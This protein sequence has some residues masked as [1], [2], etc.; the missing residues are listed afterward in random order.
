MDDIKN[1]LYALIF[2]GGGGTRLWPLSRENKPK[3]FIKLFSDL[4][5][6]QETYQRVKN[7]ISE[8]NIYVITTSAYQKQVRQELKN[9]KPHQIIVEPEKRNTGPASFLG[10]TQIYKE[11]PDA[12]IAHIWVDHKIDNWEEYANVLYRGAKVCMDEDTLLTVGLQPDFPHTGLGYLITKQEI[13][14]DVYEVRKFIEK[15]DFETAKELVDNGGAY[16]NVGIYIGCAKKFLTSFEKYAPN[17]TENIS[18]YTKMPSISIDKAISEKIPRLLM[19]KA[20]FD[21]SDIGDFEVLWEKLSDMD[22]KGNVVVSKNDWSSIDT[23][24]SLIISETGQLVTTIGLSNMAVIVTKDAILVL[25]KDESQRIK[26]LI[27]KMKESKL[28]KY[29]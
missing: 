1:N 4:S 26:E 3:Q 28:N 15:P 18:D 8:D 2:A 24:G 14:K 29:L 17:I 21:W 19:I 27:A 23:Q 20:K 10:C 12:I 9:L 5:L 11:N 13:E 25:P 22:G 16:W 6:I 7:A